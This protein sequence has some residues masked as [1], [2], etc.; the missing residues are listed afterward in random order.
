MNLAV[1]DGIKF[2][3][4]GWWIYIHRTGKLFHS[5]AYL[6]ILPNQCLN[7]VL[8]SSPQ[9]WSSNTISMLY[10]SL[11]SAKTPNKKDNCFSGF[12]NV[13]TCLL[14]NGLSLPTPFTWKELL[15]MDMKINKISRASWLLSLINFQN[16][17]QG[18]WKAVSVD[19]FQFTQDFMLL[20]YK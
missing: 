3:H 15:T 1:M 7:I 5:R 8:E 9:G 13:D 2:E 4:P 12:L 17:S 11:P 18:I 19:N 10:H 6:S 16:H 20:T 14:K